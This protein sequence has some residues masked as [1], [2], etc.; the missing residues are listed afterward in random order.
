M[1]LIDD[2][3]GRQNIDNNKINKDQELTNI[4]TLHT[5]NIENFELQQGNEI[6]G[7]RD[8]NINNGNYNENIEG[9]YIQADKID[10]SQVDKS[11]RSKNFQVGDVGG[12]FNPTNSPVMSDNSNISTSSDSDRPKKKIVL[13]WII[14]ILAITIP[15]F[16]SG[17][18]N[19]PI[20]EFFNLNSPSET[21][22]QPENT[23]TN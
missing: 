20:K 22:E 23:S 13:G 10:N 18:F 12:D 11:N 19:E 7:D 17:I 3:I 5:N 21:P 15:I 8:I 1:D 2:T 4:V 6:M 9:D 16:A 14:S